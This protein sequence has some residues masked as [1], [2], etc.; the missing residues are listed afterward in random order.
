MCRLHCRRFTNNSLRDEGRKYEGSMSYLT[1]SQ[2]HE[3][4]VSR[5]RCIFYLLPRDEGV[6]TF[7]RVRSSSLDLGN[8]LMSRPTYLFLP[9]CFYTDSCSLSTA[10]PTRSTLTGRQTIPLPTD[11]NKGI[12]RSRSAKVAYL[13]TPQNSNS[14]AEIATPAQGK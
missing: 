9:H 4:H 12:E 13:S 11:L 3:D 10:R 5:S 1:H 8:R 7:T 6:I 14:S 2:M